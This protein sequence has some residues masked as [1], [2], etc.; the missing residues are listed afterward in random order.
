VHQVGFSLYDPCNRFLLV[1]LEIACIQSAV[2]H[3]TNMAQH[4]AGGHP[5]YR[6]R[7]P[8]LRMR[9]VMQRVVTFPAQIL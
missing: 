7:V 9:H 4:T 8:R 5:S 3:N 2:Y 1:A 6:S